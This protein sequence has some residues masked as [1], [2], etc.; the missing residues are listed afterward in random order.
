VCSSLPQ[1]NSV[2]IRRHWK[3]AAIGARTAISAVR[4]ALA[5]AADEGW[6][7]AVRDRRPGTGRRVVREKFRLTSYPLIGM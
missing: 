1:D 5:E 6:F 2:P 4:V 7:D 3:R